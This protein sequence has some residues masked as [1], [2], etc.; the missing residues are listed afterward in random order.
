MF[1]QKYLHQKGYNNHIIQC[2]NAPPE[3]STV[4]SQVHAC[5]LLVAGLLCCA[6]VSWEVATSTAS[7]GELLSVVL[8]VLIATWQH[9][10]KGP[11]LLA[12]MD[13]SNMGSVATCLTHLGI[14]SA[15]ILRVE[16]VSK[17]SAIQLHLFSIC[18][19]YNGFLQC[20]YSIILN[21][22]CRILEMES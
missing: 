8:I 18:K 7:V 6:L 10:G 9:N 12:P 20:F 15:T 14:T 4:Y 11:V 16:V 22:C 13:A 17:L 3:P 5:E 1:S 2:T 21:E 19:F